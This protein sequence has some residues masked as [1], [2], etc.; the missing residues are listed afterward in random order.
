MATI[1]IVDDVAANRTR[2][3][4]V[5]GSQGHR[6]L[7]AVDGR[8][9][10]S[11]I[12]G[13]RP[14]LV[15]TDLLM[16]GMG[17]YEFV[18]RLRQDPAIDGIPVLFY[19]APYAEREAREL[20]SASGVP[21]VLTRSDGPEQVLAMVGQILSGEGRPAAMTGIGAAGSASGRRQLRL[22]G[23][24]LTA[25]AEELTAANARLR[26]LVNIGQELASARDPHSLLQG[27]CADAVDLFGAT[28]TSLGILDPDGRTVRR[29][30]TFGTD[31]PDWIAPGDSVTGLLAAVVAEGRSFRGENPDGVAT[32]LELPPGHPEVRAFLAVPIATPT[33]VYGWIKLV[34][35]EGRP[36]SDED[37]ELLLAL[38]G[39]VGRIYELEDEIQDRREAEHAL[40][41][42]RD[43]SRQYLDVAEVLIVALDP[44][45]HITLVNRHACTLLGW[46]AEE[47]VGRDW[48]ETCLPAH[49]REEVRRRVD[50]ALQ[51]DPT[52]VVN[53]VLTRAGNERLIEWRPTVMRDDAGRVTGT[54]SS[55]TDITDRTKAVTDLRQAEEQMRFALE[56][57]KVGI[58]DQDYATGV[59]SWSPR[60]EAQYGLEPGTFDGTFEGFVNRIHPDDRASVGNTVAEAI[61]AGTDFTVEHRAIW[62]D[63][64]VHWLASAGRI[65]LDADGRPARGLGISMDVTERRRLAAQYQQAQKMEAI[66][67][68]AGGVAHDF[69]NLLTVILGNCEML[70]AGGGTGGSQ[71]AEVVEIQHSARS[72]A[73]LTRQML[74]FSRQEP[75]ASVLLDLNAIITDMGLMFSRLINKDVA[76]TMTLQPGLPPILADHGQVEQLVMNLVLNARDAMPAGGRLSITTSRAN[77]KALALATPLSIMPGEY[78]VLTVADTGTGMSPEVMAHVFEP[79]FTTKSAGKGTGLGLATVH[80]IVTRSGGQVRVASEPGAGATFTVCFPQGEPVARE[81]GASPLA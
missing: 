20:A 27:V 31:Q 53:P 36:F 30:V 2:L 34:G 38:A 79:F 37:E 42:E 45:G 46:P 41:A 54:L 81:P 47:L 64:T 80:G 68:L 29:F 19:T 21:Y 63:G 4:R 9:A 74:A 59:L 18:R 78:V 24:Q 44:A 48:F 57:A 49:C 56:G 60:L 28:Y 13:D 67:R 77:G 51:G 7:E 71:D 62:P 73:A 35:N 61:R 14:D 26:A 75:I 16:P 25:S 69:S 70:L 39:Q 22:L 32:D 8:A 5:L 1:L 65:H 50:A 52:V 55:G 58:W 6:F 23:A 11:L 12:Q 15:I 33:T 72:A 66:G 76:V 43:R 10:L 3:V 40:R 17:G